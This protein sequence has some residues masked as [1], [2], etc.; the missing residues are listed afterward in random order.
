MPAAPA[1]SRRVVDSAVISKSS[2]SDFKAGMCA[3]AAHPRSGLAPMMPTRI[4]LALPLLIARRRSTSGDDRRAF[5][6]SNF[7]GQC[8]H[9]VGKACPDL[10]V[11]QL[12]FLEAGVGMGNWELDIEYPRAERRQHFPQLR[13]RPGRPEGAGARTDHEHR[14]VPQHVR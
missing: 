7:L 4:F 8:R 3:C 10:L 12:A 11:G 6:L 1:D 2:D 9:G 14:L 13:L 5:A